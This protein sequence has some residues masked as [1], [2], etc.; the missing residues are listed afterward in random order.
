MGTD[1]L[2][3]IASKDPTPHGCPKGFRDGALMFDIEIG[4][5]PPGVELARR[6]K[7]ARRAFIDAPSAG[8]TEALESRLQ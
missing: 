8:A 6:D 1:V 2:T 5:T 3:D 7:G 4:N